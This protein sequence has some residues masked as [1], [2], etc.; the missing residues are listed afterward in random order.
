MTPGYRAALTEIL[1][2]NSEMIP[3]YYKQQFLYADTIHASHG[4]LL[5]ERSNDDG[6]QSVDDGPDEDGEYSYEH[7]E[8]DSVDDDK[9]DL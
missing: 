4:S 2:N 9:N 5:P 1:N 3:E 8:S 7:D 6:A